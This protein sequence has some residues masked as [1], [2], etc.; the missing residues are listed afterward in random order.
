MKTPSSSIEGAFDTVTS[1]LFSGIYFLSPVMKLASVIML[2]IGFA[3]F[4]F[5]RNVMFLVMSMSLAGMLNFAPVLLGTDTE[6]SYSSAS[7]HVAEKIDLSGFI[8]SGDVRS[9]LEGVEQYSA[10]GGFILNETIKSSNA[11][12]D[13]A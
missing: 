12:Q 13:D 1:S 10:R 8:K 2:I 6:E 11:N 4:I 7:S 3:A 9:F 5:N